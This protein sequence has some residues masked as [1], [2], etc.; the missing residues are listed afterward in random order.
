MNGKTRIS[1]FPKPGSGLR[2]YITILA[3]PFLNPMHN[4][5]IAFVYFKWIQKV[6]TKNNTSNL[7]FPK[8]NPR[9]ADK[10]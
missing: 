9:G 6:R 5:K 3:R 7:D 4:G 2:T 10:E 8:S 1:L